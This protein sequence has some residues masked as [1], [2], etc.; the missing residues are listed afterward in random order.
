MWEVIDWSQGLETDCCDGFNGLPSFLKGN[1][2]IIYLLD[3][4]A[5]WQMKQT[6]MLPFCNSMLCGPWS[7][8]S[9]VGEGGEDMYVCVYIYIYIYIYSGSGVGGHPSPLKCVA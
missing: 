2:G 5:Y 6:D 3:L 4:I 9:L 8:I 7:E 1:A